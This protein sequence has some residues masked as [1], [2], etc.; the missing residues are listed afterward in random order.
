MAAPAPHLPGV[1]FWRGDAADI[2]VYQGPFQAAFLN[3]AFEALRDPSDTLARVLLRVAPGGHL[4]ISH[5]QGRKAAE[6]KRK[7]L[8]DV[9]PQS[10]PTERRVGTPLRPLV[11]L[12]SHP[13]T[14]SPCGHSSSSRRLC[15]ARWLVVAR[16]EM[17]ALVHS[18]PVRLVS[19][20]DGEKYLAVLQASPSNVPFPFPS[21]FWR[22]TDEI[23]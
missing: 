5:P 18:L 20:E 1:R 22:S 12:S 7:A 15:P 13:H 10:L 16:S 14:L 21:P 3:G 8:P 19:F 6:A 4:V 23:S 9:Y 17:K 2:P 11:T